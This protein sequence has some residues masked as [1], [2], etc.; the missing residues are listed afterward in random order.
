VKRFE[1]IE[2]QAAEMPI[3]CLCDVLQVSR[4][5]YYAWC[6]WKP[7][8]RD[9]ED[10]TLTDVIGEIF[11]D[12]LCCYGSLRIHAALRQIGYLV[13]RKRVARLMH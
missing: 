10:Q 5:G 9:Q 13:S 2:Q 3:S 4:S 7:S 11:H 1:A 6:G 12:N 8:Q